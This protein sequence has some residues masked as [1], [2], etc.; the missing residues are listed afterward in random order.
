MHIQIINFNLKGISRA[1]Y[2]A[3]SDEIVGLFASM[4]G[5][6]S[7]TWLANEETNTYGGVYF[8]ENKEAMDSYIQSEVF[9]GIGENPALENIKSTDFEVIEGL[10]KITK[11]I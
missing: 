2:E 9:K 3:A 6:V 4:P 11:G 7:K 5:L 1:E 10:S 8:W